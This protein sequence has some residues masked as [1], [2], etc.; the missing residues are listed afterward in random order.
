MTDTPVGRWGVVDAA[1][2]SLANDPQPTI[3]VEVGL[4]PATIHLG[5]GGNRLAW[6]SDLF[7]F[8]LLLKNEAYGTAAHLGNKGPFLSGNPDVESKLFVLRVLLYGVLSL[9]GVLFGRPVQKRSTL[10]RGYSV[11]THSLYLER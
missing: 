5:K 11:I 4:S 6:K 3:H 2:H 10:Y 1:V 7:S 8:T 9:I